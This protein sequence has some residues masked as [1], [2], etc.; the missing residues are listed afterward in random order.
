MTTHDFIFV[1][2]GNVQN[3]TA[4]DTENITGYTEIL[5]YVF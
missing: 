3:E 5:H 4:A 1:V 2:G